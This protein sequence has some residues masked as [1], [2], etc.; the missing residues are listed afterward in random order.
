M[1]A[2]IY[3]A[4][5]GMRACNNNMRNPIIRKGLRML[6]LLHALIPC[7]AAYIRTALVS[8]L[9]STV[10]PTSFNTL[11]EMFYS[12]FS[13]HRNSRMPCYVS[14]KAYKSTVQEFCAVQ[15]RL[16]GRVGTIPT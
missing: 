3:A 14:I 6:L 16:Y 1:W 15:L 4:K 2:V 12:A 9:F 11:M 5:Q 8:L 13:L 7:F 10:I